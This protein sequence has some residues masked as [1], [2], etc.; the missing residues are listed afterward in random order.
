MTLPSV[1]I[2]HYT[3]PPTVGG[4]E[5]LMGVHARLF[6]EAGYPTRVIT[7]RGEPFRAD[8]PVVVIPSL[9]SKDPKLLDVNDRLDRG[10]V[11]E[12]F[13]RLTERIYRS[14]VDAMAGVDCCI[15]HNAFT[16]HF[17]LPLTAALHRLNAVG[18]GP[19]FVSWCHDVSWKNELYIPRMRDRIPLESAEDGRWRVSPTWPCPPRGRQSSRIA[20]LFR[21]RSSGWCLAGVDPTGAA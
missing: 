13:H 8:V 12:P 17:N 10:V 9:Y 11:D 14:L 18:K 1:A 21:R 5:I 7:G 15:V 19:R 20:S 2:L 6:S 3:C 16:L 4:V